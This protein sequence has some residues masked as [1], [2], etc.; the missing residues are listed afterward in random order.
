[1][2]KILG[3]YENYWYAEKAFISS[4]LDSQVSEILLV[5]FT[6]YT[7]LLNCTPYI[8]VYSH[9]LKPY[10]QVKSHFWTYFVPWMYWFNAVL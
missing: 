10:T 3:R 9:L 5:C 8:I 2:E 4:D 6:H 7:V 1:M